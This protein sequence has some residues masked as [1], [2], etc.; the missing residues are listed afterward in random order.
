MAAKEQ[1]NIK[2]KSRGSYKQFIYDHLLNDVDIPGH[3]K[4]LLKKKQETYTK[5]DAFR[6]L[7]RRLK[8]IWMVYACF[9]HSGK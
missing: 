7:F 8:D 6:G 4:E 3:V 1:D 9:E 2:R 5:G